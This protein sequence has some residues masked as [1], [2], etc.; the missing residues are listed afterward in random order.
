MWENVS[1]DLDWHAA[2]RHAHECVADTLESIEDGAS[3]TGAELC[4]AEGLA[5]GRDAEAVVPVPGHHHT[6]G[7]L[8][9]VRVDETKERLGLLGQRADK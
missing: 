4:I 3:Q 9:G 8:P 7:A 6:G 5:V 1:P 2:E